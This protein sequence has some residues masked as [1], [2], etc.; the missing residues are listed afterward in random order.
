MALAEDLTLTTAPDSRDDI[1][2][3]VGLVVDVLRTLPVEEAATR[4]GRYQNMLV[5][6]EAELF[7]RNHLGA[8]LTGTT[9]T[10]QAEGRSPPRPTPRNGPNVVLR[11]VRTLNSQTTS[12][13]GSWGPARSMRLRTRL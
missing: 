5:A 2:D 7:A 1:D 6:L 4:A 11:L 12:P 3:A 10:W 13:P 9:R 8:P